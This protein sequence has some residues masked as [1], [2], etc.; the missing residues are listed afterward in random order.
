MFEIQKKVNKGSWE[1]EWREDARRGRWKREKGGGPS[2]FIAKTFEILEVPNY[3]FRMINIMTQ[4]VGIKMEPISPS[5]MSKDSNKKFFQPIFAIEIFPHLFVS[6]TCMISI[7]YAMNK[8]RAYSNIVN[9]VETR[10]IFSFTQAT[11]QKH[12]Q[13]RMH[14]QK[15]Q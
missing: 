13:K 6:S 14:Q 11:S 2:I 9:S 5:Q 7:R 10:G 1:N 15:N 12:S 3:P 4:L 8:T